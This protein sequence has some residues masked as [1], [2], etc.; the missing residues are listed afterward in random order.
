M[1]REEKDE[2]GEKRKT[3]LKSSVQGSG[4]LSFRHSGRSK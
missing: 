4:G 1:K 3:S 2:K